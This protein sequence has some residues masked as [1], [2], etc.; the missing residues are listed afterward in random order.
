LENRVIRNETT[1]RTEICRKLRST[2]FCAYGDKCRF[3]HDESELRVKLVS[4]FQIPF[5]FNNPQINPNSFSM[6]DGGPFQ[7]LF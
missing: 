1:F 7:N 6:P 2:G 3:A 5:L 4:F